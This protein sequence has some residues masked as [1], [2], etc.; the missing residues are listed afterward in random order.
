MKKILPSPTVPVPYGF[1]HV[2][3]ARCRVVKPEC[4]PVHMHKKVR[5]VIDVFVPVASRNQGF[6]TTLMHSI[7]R[8][9]DD[10]GITLF[11]K[12]E[13]FG[14]TELSADMLAGWYANSFGFALI[15]KDPPLM[16]RM[17]W[18]TPTDT[19]PNINAITAAALKAL[20]AEAK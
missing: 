10:H 1:R 16:A 3:T 17:P 8:E 18:S 4:L 9:A 6:A 7:C 12:V 14:D 11:L 15:Q 5:E 20:K 2:N 13:P 19:L